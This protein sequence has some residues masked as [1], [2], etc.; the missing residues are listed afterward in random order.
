M[1]R[2]IALSVLLLGGCATV[3]P[4]FERP[5]PPADTAYVGEAAQA[6]A[7][8]ATFGQGPGP[9]WWEAFGSPALDALVDRAA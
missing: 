5:A 8:A 9:Q 4:D 6:G 7:P 1:K 2:V 3:G